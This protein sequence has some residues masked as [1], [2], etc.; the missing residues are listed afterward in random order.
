VPGPPVEILEEASFRAARGGTAAMLPDAGGRLRP[1]R[2]LLAELVET[3]RPSAR[4]LGCEAEL[5][6]APGLAERGGGAGL[7]RAAGLDGVLRTLLDAA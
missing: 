4:E 2:E 7:Q 3:V 1:A 5:D 6:A